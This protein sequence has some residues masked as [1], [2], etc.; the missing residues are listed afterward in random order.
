[1]SKEIVKDLEYPN[2]IQL[3]GYIVKSLTPSDVEI[4]DEIQ[5][6]AQYKAPDSTTVQGE[7]EKN[8]INGVGFTKHRD[9]QEYIGFFKKNKRHGTGC[10]F[11]GDKMITARFE[12]GKVGNF[13]EVE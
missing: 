10:L 9:G 7:F 4:K 12:E 13:C 11:L 8:E 1:M 3:T 6:F 5:G 2:G